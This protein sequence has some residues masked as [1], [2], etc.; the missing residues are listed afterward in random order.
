MHCLA[1]ISCHSHGDLIQSSFSFSSSR[2]WRRRTSI[3]AELTRD[4]RTLMAQRE[5]RKWGFSSP[6][7]T[8]E[9]SSSETTFIEN[10]SM[11]PSAK[12]RFPALLLSPRG[13]G[14]SKREEYPLLGWCRQKIAREMNGHSSAQSQSER[15]RNRER[16]SDESGSVLLGRIRRL[17][18]VRIEEWPGLPYVR[19]ENFKG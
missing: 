13:V 5:R 7:S 11:I 16:L 19:I 8:N 9:I 1:W 12:D 15:K 2:L 10:R 3:E 14:C 6:S 4:E 17:D 18:F